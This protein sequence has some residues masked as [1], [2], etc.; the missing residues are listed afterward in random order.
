M[1]QVKNAFDQFIVTLPVTSIRPQHEVTYD[2]RR[3]RCYQQI[4]SSV[5][6]I[7]LIEPL[8]VFRASPGD[9]LLLD[10]HSRLD[11]LKR[12]GR[13]EVECILS[14]DDEAYTFNQRVNSIPSVAQH[15]MILKAIENG[16]TEE[17][18]AASLRVNVSVIN[19]KRD[20][21]D[22]ICDEAVKLLQTRKVS[23]LS[24]SLLKKM[25]PERQIESA[26]HM[27]ASSVNSATFVRALLAATKSD[28][29]VNQ[30]KPQKRPIIPE[31]TKA[32]FA[33]E[34]DALLK[35]L[36][37]LEA[38]LG[39]EALT[40][41]VFRGYVR[42]LVRNTRVKRYLEREHKEILEVLGSEISRTELQLGLASQTE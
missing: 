6:E 29:L 9:Y 32:Q 5:N 41:T 14:S 38:D 40:L 35:D 15:L 4:A 16:L 25:K 34:S 24:F 28:L 11:A 18:I 36:K 12:I 26:K 13:T 1:A 20:M 42:R 22:G 8:V 21:L 17:R 7:G 19:R 27:V 31:S 33:Q 3:G 10:G 2:H 39:K 37:G 30:R 23:A